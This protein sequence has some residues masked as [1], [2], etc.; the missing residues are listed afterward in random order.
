[1]MMRKVREQPKPS[2]QKLFNGLKAHVQVCLKFASEH[3]NDSEDL[4][5]KCC[6]Q[7]K[8]NLSYLASTRAA[9][10]RG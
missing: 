8:P 3:L 2:W 7:M 1:M 4:G 5:E 10:F 6:G 9:T